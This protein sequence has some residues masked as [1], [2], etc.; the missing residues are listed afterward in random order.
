MHCDLFID[1]IMM[2]YM[3]NVLITTWKPHLLDIDF[4]EK[5]QKNERKRGR[6]IT[7]YKTKY[8]KINDNV[9]LEG[10][11]GCVVFFCIPSNIMKV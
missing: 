11:V 10:L 2:N 1:S 4:I 7:W 3:K 8:F 9:T 5:N 6:Y